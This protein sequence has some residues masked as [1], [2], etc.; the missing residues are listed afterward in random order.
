MKDPIVEEVRKHRM[1]HT[2]KFD[3]DLSAICAAGL[4]PNTTRLPLEP[5]ALLKDWGRLVRKML[6]IPTRDQYRRDGNFSPG[7]FEKRI[8]PWSAI[9]GKF[10]SFAKDNPE[11]VDVV[12]L[13]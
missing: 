1:E 6:Q 7:V 2:R 3:G 11:W 9:P 8:G 5:A 12:A 13:L 10:R 4:E